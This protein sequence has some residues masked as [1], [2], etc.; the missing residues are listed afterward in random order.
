MAL[1]NK[2]LIVFIALLVVVG[3]FEAGCLY[4]VK[5]NKPKA[6]VPAPT[7]KLPDKYCNIDPAVFMTA[8]NTDKMIK[9]GVLTGANVT[10]TYKGEV[11]E[12]I[13]RPSPNP[14]A[15][16]QQ[17]E[18]A[19][20]LQKSAEETDETFGFWFNKSELANLKVEKTSGGSVSKTTLQELQK[21][22]KV[23]VTESFD[24]AK[25]GTIL[26]SITVQ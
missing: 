6:I 8:E 13:F 9:S 10:N 2:L 26:Y 1:Q 25:K 23:T 5:F 22:D 24:M 17:Y 18:A 21:G 14:D 20:R 3:V 16:G 12:V 11:I 4:S 7:V 15:P 19:L